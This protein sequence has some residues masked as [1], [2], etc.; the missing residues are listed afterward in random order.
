MASRSVGL[1]L[2]SGLALVLS[3]AP[4][5]A[6]EFWVDPVHGSPAGDGSQANPWRTL[7]EVV[8][9]GLIETRDWESHPYAP[10][11]GFVVVN[12]GAPV[13]AGDTIWLESGY[14]GELVL[15]GA[16][17]AEPITLAAAPGATPTL[18]RVQLTGTQNWILRGVSISPSFATPPLSPSTIVEIRSDDGW[19]GPS[20]DD[21]VADG[22]I[23]TVADASGWTANDWVDG[24]SSAVYVS[25]DRIGIRNNRIRNV[26]FGISVDGAD[27]R[28]AD[29]LIDGFSADGMR[30]LGDGDVFEY[31]RVQNC[32]VGDPPDGNHDDGFQSWSVG[33]GGVGTGE[34]VGVVLRG[35]VFIDDLDPG[36]PLNTT[37]QGIGCFDGMFRNWVVE[38]NVVVT[39]HWH[40]ISFYGMLDSRI[41]NNTVLDVNDTSPGPPWIMVTDSNGTP[42]ENV[43]VRNNLA[44]D[45]QISGV[46]IVADHNL[47]IQDPASLFVA[48]PFDVHPKAGSAAIDAGSAALAPVRDADRI[49]RPQGNGTDLGATSAAR[50]AS[51]STASSP[52]PPAPGAAPA[53]RRRRKIRDGSVQDQRLPWKGEWGGAS[54]AAR[55][56]G[57]VAQRRRVQGTPSKP[58]CPL[59]ESTASPLRGP[60]VCQREGR[61]RWC[62]GERVP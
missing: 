58:G 59:G 28:I 32:Y 18:S 14:H 31:N 7:Q 13:K 53:R 4:V 33:P 42:S 17:N 24:A 48:P 5:L 43:V 50:A 55:R 51:S 21:V 20:W 40:G 36:N 49:P 27:A 37:M 12:P 2:A 46:D 26:R 39:D 34:V 1:L 62:G 29:N 10:G 25:G 54:V 38:D 3:S 15:H 45:Y 52:A 6:T 61:R 60:E 16:Y 22:E 11:L 9:A 35:N 30:G 44:T 19:W 8:E 47:L 56:A 57:A 41:V 23:F